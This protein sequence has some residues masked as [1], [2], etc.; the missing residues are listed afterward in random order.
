MSDQPASDP[1]SSLVNQLGVEPTAEPPPPVVTP[2]TSPTSPQRSAGEPRPAPRP[3][4]KTNWGLVANELG[5]DAPPE[6]E[7]PPEQPAKKSA[8]ESLVRGDL[9]GAR[10]PLRGL[11]EHRETTKAPLGATTIGEEV[12]NAAVESAVVM[13]AA[14]VAATR[15]TVALGVA[16]AIGPNLV[17][18]IRDDVVRG[19]VVMEAAVRAAAARVAV[20][21]AAEED[22]ATRGAR[23][24]AVVGLTVQ[25]L[26]H[27][28]RE[29]DTSAVSGKTSPGIGITTAKMTSSAQVKRETR[30]E[31]NN[32]AK[33]TK[34][35]TSDPRCVSRIVWT[36][37]RRPRSLML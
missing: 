37:D 24:E 29:G 6:P 7:A 5:I 31:P 4:P 14:A 2:P 12:M 8:I 3:K 26:K 35:R 11:P 36:S 23:V 18:V 20:I 13:D 1:W 21:R 34:E 16:A 17:V 30:S 22:M 32:F 33:I 19:A 28:T 27:A 10:K 9:G 25:R 15:A